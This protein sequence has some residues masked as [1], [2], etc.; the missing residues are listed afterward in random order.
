MPKKILNWEKIKAQKKW[1]KP[2]KPIENHPK[3]I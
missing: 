2:A 1:P 3:P